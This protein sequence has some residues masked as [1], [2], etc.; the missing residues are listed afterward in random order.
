MV[1][2]SV[3]TSVV[4]V[5]NRPLSLPVIRRH[6]ASPLVLNLHSMNFVDTPV[7][8]HARMD[9]ALALADRITVNSAYVANRLSESFGSRAGRIRVIYPGVDDSAFHPCRSSVDLAARE[10][11]RTHHQSAQAIVVLFV[12]RIVARKGLHTVLEALQHLRPAPGGRPVVLWIAG[13]KP[14][15][16]SPYE[17]RL[18]DLARGLPVRYLGYVLR[19]DL[20][21]LYRAADI[22]VCPSQKPEAFG[23]VNLEAQASGLPVLA[24]HAWGIRESV[25]NGQTGVLVP[26]YADAQAWARILREMCQDRSA[27]EQLAARA[28]K[29]VQS[30]FS[31][32]ASAKRFAQLY[33][34]LS[35]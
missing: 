26:D 9:A 15:F 31:W 1:H 25:V 8:S 27:R 5:D 6:M 18:R 2:T 7:V 17:K 33:A 22:F 16:G 30:R 21:A 20:P 23:L 24:S 3:A 29:L 13:R 4:Q 12:G 19:K 11:L 32:P 10:S 28:V 14:P 35:R 34:D